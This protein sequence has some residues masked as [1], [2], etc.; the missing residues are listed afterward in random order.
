MRTPKQCHCGDMK[1][2]GHKCAIKLQSYVVGFMFDTNGQF[3]NLIQ[4]I[5]PEWQKGLFNGVGG[6]IE[7]GE[8]AYDAMIREFKEE[9]GVHCEDW[10]MF[11]QIS[12]PGLSSWVVYFFYAFSVKVFKTLS[13]TDEEVVLFS[14]D[15]L[16]KNIITNVRWLIP[17]ALDP[18][19]RKDVITNEHV[20]SF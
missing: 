17:M 20:A 13:V 14:V 7:K 4:K 6:K 15:H 12:G 18:N 9:T 16:P 5:K 2:R 8:S 1:V 19:C 11:M 3:V 10:T